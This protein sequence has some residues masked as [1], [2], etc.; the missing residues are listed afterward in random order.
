MLAAMDARSATVAKPGEL[1]PKQ[2]AFVR[3]YLI[4]RNGTQAAIRAGYSAKTAKVIAT[5]NLTKPAIIEK[6][7]LATE[8]Q[9]EQ[10]GITTDWVWRK[11]KEEAEDYSEFSSHS[12]RVRCTEIAAKLLGMFKEDNEQK[13]TPLVQL[14]LI[15]RPNIA[16][17]GTFAIP[18]D[19]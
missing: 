2:A 7:R 17:P 6:V 1:T 18:E 9:S 15:L 3:E 14:A 13:A 5:E 8:K 4:D 10:T 12:A 11:L 16:G 19:D